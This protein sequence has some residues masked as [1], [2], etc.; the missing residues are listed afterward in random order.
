MLFTGKIFR[1]G[2]LFSRIRHPEILEISQHISTRIPAL[3]SRT[4]TC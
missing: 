1:V 3:D 4:N 2:F